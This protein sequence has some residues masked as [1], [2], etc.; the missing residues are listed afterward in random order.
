MK[1]GSRNCVLKVNRLYT[2]VDFGIIEFVLLKF[3]TCMKSTWTLN[4]Q[5]HP[6]YK[7]LFHKKKPP[8]YFFKRILATAVL[9]SLGLPTAVLRTSKERKKYIPR[10]IR[11]LLFFRKQKSMK[12]ISGLSLSSALF[13]AVAF[14]LSQAIS[15]WSAWVMIT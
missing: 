13:F 11:W 2:G 12:F 15:R 4:C 5:D 8:Q 14:F 10:A 6:N 7:I 9:I 1:W 3:F